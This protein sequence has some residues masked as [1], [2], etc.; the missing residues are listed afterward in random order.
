M[1]FKGVAVAAAAL[2]IASCAQHARVQG[3]VDGASNSDIV[4]SLLQVNTLEVLD[5]VKTDANGRFNVKVDVKKGQPEFVYL[6]R[7]GVRI[8]P[9]LLQAGDKL[10]VTADSLGNCTVSGNPEAELYASMEKDYVA[11]ASKVSEYIEADDVKNA[12]LEYINYYRNCLRFI[13]EHPYSIVNVPLMYQTVADGV[14]VFGQQTDAIHFTRVCDSLETVYPDS[15]YVKALRQAAEERRNYLDFQMMMNDAGSIGYIDIELPDI[16]AQKQ[17]LSDVKG[18]V[19]LLHYWTLTPEQKMMNLDVLLPIYKEYHNLG[20]EIYQVALESDKTSWAATM[21]AQEL[22][23]VNV[24]DVNEASSKY[25]SLYA[26]Q[27]LP[28]TYLIANDELVD[29]Q[30]STE[31]DLRKLLDK[32]LK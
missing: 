16:Y 13:A 5:T 31:G 27:S 17:K 15:R 24:C 1:F 22:P 30:F 28:S 4:V 12:R 23:W 2:S 21:R 25:V 10:T 7:N 20:L 32:L 18:K 19:V 8:A 9:L 11:F 3:V 6:Y 29:A 26:L 14:P